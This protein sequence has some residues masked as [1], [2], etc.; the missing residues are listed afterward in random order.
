MIKTEEII[1]ERE[2]EEETTEMLYGVDNGD[3]EITNDPINILAKE[4]VIEDEFA[5]E[6]NFN[7]DFSEDTNEDQDSIPDFF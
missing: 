4:E 1:E 3:I 2:T 6:D 5:K 7:L